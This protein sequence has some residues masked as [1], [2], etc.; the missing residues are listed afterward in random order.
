MTPTGVGLPPPFTYP[1]PRAGPV[2]M[3]TVSPTSTRQDPA[4]GL[5]P[6]TL[7]H[8]EGRPH[9]GPRAPRNRVCT[10]SRVPLPLP[11]SGG[12]LG[13]A[14]RIGDDHLPFISSPQQVG[15]QDDGD[16]TGRHLVGV[17][18]LCEFS[19]ELDEVP[20]DERVA[21]HSE[22]PGQHLPVGSGRARRQCSGTELSAQR[23][24]PLRR[25]P[26]VTRPPWAV[27]FESLSP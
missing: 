24:K 27:C 12:K 6:G 9:I 20:E 25:E 17:T 22:T 7:A 26:Q 14:A 3:R 10:T 1:L 5:A 16:V 19:K 23:R 4:H 2:T 15:A 13:P 8:W 11:L 18:G 21:T